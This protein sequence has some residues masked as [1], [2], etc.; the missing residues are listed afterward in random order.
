MHCLCKEIGTLCKAPF[1]P[2]LSYRKQRAFII[3]AL[4]YLLLS[5]T[6][7]GMG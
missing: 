2:P 7:E 5:Y 6:L 3:S 1:P 4:D